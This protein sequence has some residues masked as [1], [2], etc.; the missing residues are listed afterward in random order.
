[1]GSLLQPVE[2]SVVLVDPRIQHVTRSGRS[3]QHLLRDFHDVQ[4]AARAAAVPVHLILASKAPDPRE[5][6]TAPDQPAASIHITSD[7]G[8]SRSKSSLAETLAAQG[9][10][11]SFCAAL[12]RG[13]QGVCPRKVSMSH[14]ALRVDRIRPPSPRTN[15][16]VGQGTP[17]GPGN[18]CAATSTIKLGPGS[19]TAGRDTSAPCRRPGPHP[20]AGPPSRR[21]LHRRSLPASR[22]SEPAPVR[23]L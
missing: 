8:P 17:T 10:P 12:A 20:Y 19:G 23:G 13:F 9:R 21:M 16:Y 7:C 15:I 6:P 3:A 1:M 2:C 11:P 14:M 22:I 18:A 4:V 5:V